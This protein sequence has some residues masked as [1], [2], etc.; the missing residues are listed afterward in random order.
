MD[1]NKMIQ[2]MAPDVQARLLEAAVKEKN[3]DMVMQISQI[4]CEVPISEGGMSSEDI[5]TIVE[6]AMADMPD[7]NT[8]KNSNKPLI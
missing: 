6:N 2:S 7:Y 3:I 5:A 8:N 1:I 4:L